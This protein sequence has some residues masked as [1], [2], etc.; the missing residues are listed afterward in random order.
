MPEK[1]R[2]VIIDTFRI[3]P[4]YAIHNIFVWDANRW[5]IHFGIMGSFSI[6]W[7][8]MDIMKKYNMNIQVPGNQ[9]YLW[10]LTISDC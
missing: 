8:D 9:E 5:C 10:S 4:K 7:A 6:S 1:L 2:E 3:E